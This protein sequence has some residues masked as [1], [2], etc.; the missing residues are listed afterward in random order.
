[1]WK[2]RLIGNRTENCNKMKNKKIT[3]L[4]LIIFIFIGAVFVYTVKYSGNDS[5]VKSLKSLAPIEVAD[6]GVSEKNF[7]PEDTVALEQGKELV[8]LLS[9]LNS[10]EIDTSF[11]DNPLFESFKDFSVQLPAANIGAPNPFASLDSGGE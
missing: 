9:T 11:F 4:L 5:A 3:T 2:R 7:S 1:M 10:I 8:R 6:I